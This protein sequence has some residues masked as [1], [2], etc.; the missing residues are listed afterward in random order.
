MFSKTDN[1]NARRHIYN[2]LKSEIVFLKIK[3]GSVLSEIETAKRFNVSRTPIR[4][5]FLILQQEKLIEVYPQRGSY[6]TKIDLEYVE[7]ILYM[8]T[9]IEEQIFCD[10][11]KN[12]TSA[13]FLKLEYL[14]A[15]QRMVNDLED[16]I[17]KFIELDS[18]FHK[19]IFRIANKENLWDTIDGLK[20]YMTRFIM[21]SYLNSDTIPV[22]CDHHTNLIQLLKAGAEDHEIK[23]RIHNH[24]YYDFENADKV[25]KVYPN[26]FK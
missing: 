16:G 9:L 25:K 7:S 12:I 5:I 22:L 1:E 14:I 2:V 24:F 10:A 11:K 20:I 15:N 19:E 17:M 8:R 6:V 13:D 26:F 4:D 21:L 3:P 18:E 23:E